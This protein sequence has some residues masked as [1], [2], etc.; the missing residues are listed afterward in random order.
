MSYRSLLSGYCG[1][2]HGSSNVLTIEQQLIMIKR[3]V[4]H[5]WSGIL[6]QYS[7]QIKYVLMGSAVNM[8]KVIKEN[9]GVGTSILGHGRE[10]PQ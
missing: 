4:C 5:S 7:I 1:R 3:Y 8:L 6:L 10:V 9:P 2:I